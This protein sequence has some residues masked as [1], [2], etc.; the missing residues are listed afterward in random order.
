MDEKPMS[1]SARAVCRISTSRQAATYNSL[2]KHTVTNP[3]IRD[4]VLAHM[5]NPKDRAAYKEALD[6]AFQQWTHPR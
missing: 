2:A 6:K 1:S 4:E 3:D 5:T